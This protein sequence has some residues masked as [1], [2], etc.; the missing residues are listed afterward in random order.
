MD[1]SILKLSEFEKEIFIIYN[2]FSK[3][4]RDPIISSKNDKWTKDGTKEKTWIQ[5]YNKL[6]I[7]SHIESLLFNQKYEEKSI[8]TEMEQYIS[9][10]GIN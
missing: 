5:I 9:S 7:D 6:P 1:N 8:I 2:N 10:N 3:Y 4:Y